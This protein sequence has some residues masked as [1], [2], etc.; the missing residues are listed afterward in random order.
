MGITVKGKVLEEVL[1]LSTIIKKSPLVPVKLGTIVGL[2]LCLFF[3]AGAFEYPEL[4][5]LDARYRLRGEVSPSQDIVIVGITQRCL[6]RLGK[7]PW[8]RTYHAELIDFL[9]KAGA[10]V[11]VMDIFF[12]QPDPDPLVDQRFSIAIKEAGNVILPVF[13]PYRISRLAQ[14]D[15]FIYVEDLVESTE[16]FSIAA[17][18]QGHINMLPDQDGIYRKA[19]VA[20]KYSE[21]IFFSLGIEAAI[22]F[23]NIQMDIFSRSTP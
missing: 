9:K 8:P 4:G 17:L 18:S 20:I 10:R 6:N 15:N 2:V 16:D 7:F 1:R 21:K 3:S 13:T 23:L 12:A 19:A 5:V 11:I 22:K 14:D